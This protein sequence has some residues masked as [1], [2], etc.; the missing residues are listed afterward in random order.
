MKEGIVMKFN[1]IIDDNYLSYFVL[2]KAMN[3]QSETLNEIKNELINDIGYKK[4]I[5]NEMLDLSIYLKNEKISTLLEK[6]IKSDIFKEVCKNYDIESERKLAIMI[7]SEKIKISDSR[8]EDLKN[9]LWNSDRQ[10]YK[11]VF[12]INEF[13]PQYYLIDNDVIKTINNFKNTLEFK[14]IHQETVL[15]CDMI[16]KYWNQVSDEIVSFLK[17]I[18]RINIDKEFDVYITHPDTC[19]GFSFN[20]SIAWGHFKGLSDMNYNI[21][22]LIHESLHNLIPF[23]LDETSDS[24]SIKHSIIELISDY[25]LYSKLSGVSKYNVGHP[26]LKEYRNFVYPYWLK[27]LGLNNEQIIERIKFDGLDTNEFNLSK[28]NIEALNINE[29]IKFCVKEYTDMILN[30]H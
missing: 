5:G 10:G 17:N 25:E 22:Y 14:K 30:N 7:L 16:K 6:V 28:V 29:F 19:T 12:N 26:N 27:Y 18:L 8:L 1:F 9:E 11:D 4:I 15:Y 24:A 13:N 23:D 2:E 3:N 20:G 21:V